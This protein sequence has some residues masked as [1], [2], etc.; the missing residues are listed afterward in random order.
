MDIQKPRLNL[1]CDISV[2]LERCYFALVSSI[3][4]SLIL[5]ISNVLINYPILLH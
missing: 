1:N 2:C 5:L 3:F 4:K